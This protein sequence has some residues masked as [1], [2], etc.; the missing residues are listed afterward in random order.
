MPP[1]DRLTQDGVAHVNCSRSLLRRTV[2]AG[3]LRFSTAAGIEFVLG[4]GDG[5][6]FGPACEGPAYGLTRLTELSAYCDDVLTG[7]D[8][9]GVPVDQLHP[10]HAPGQFEISVGATDPVA[11][12]ATASPPRP[13]RSP[14]AS[15]TR[16]RR[17]PR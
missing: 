13:R 9:Q 16:S 3:D 7:L 1:V 11:A 2:A 8:A 15:S 6:D 10:E 5:P 4:R 14:P 17:R 12:A